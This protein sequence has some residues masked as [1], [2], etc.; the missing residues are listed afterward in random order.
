MKPADTEEQASQQVTNRKNSMRGQ[1]NGWYES[2][3]KLADIKDSRSK[4]F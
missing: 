1:I 2:L 3:R 4:F